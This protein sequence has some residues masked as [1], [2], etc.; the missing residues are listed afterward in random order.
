MGRRVVV[1]SVPTATAA[2]NAIRAMRAYGGTLNMNG[3]RE[4]YPQFI[5]FS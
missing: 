2:T 5:V 4:S 1:A 3:R